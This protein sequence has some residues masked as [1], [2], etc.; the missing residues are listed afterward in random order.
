MG[1]S[2]NDTLNGGSGN[3]M[4]YG[5]DGDDILNGNAG[6]DI[7]YG[8]EGYDTLYGGAG[9]DMLDGGEGNDY[10]EGGRGSDTY[11]FGRGYGVDT[12][13][14]AVSSGDISTVKFSTD[15]SL[16][17]IIFE[18]RGY[19]LVI[20]IKGTE[21]MLVIQGH[22]NRNYSIFSQNY[23]VDQ[24]EFADGTILTDADISEM[25]ILL[26][27]TDGDD[28]LTTRAKSSLIKG[29]YGNDNLNGGVGDDVL[30]GGAGNDYLKGGQGSDTYIFGLGYGVDTI[31]DNSGINTL[32]F[33]DGL[34][35][36]DL[37]FARNG[38][39]LEIS[40]AG[41]ADKIIVEGHF[42]YTKNQMSTYEF[43]DGTTWS[44]TDF[45]AKP[46]LVQGSQDDD[47]LTGSSYNLNE[48]YGG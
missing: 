47:V 43:G 1:S 27:G 33:L 23:Y 14:N 10:L 4:L 36:D 17:D 35:P 3:D 45:N 21:D 20:R 30:D 37:L 39:N 32:K 7:L 26:E 16:D 9:N 18:Q 22:Y 25:Q 44:G 34:S 5:G 46:I 2:E 29:G 8:G 38:N 19:D 31:E 28:I 42:S 13:K 41:T 40:I 11:I 15:I 12:I 6:N 24:Y 48:M